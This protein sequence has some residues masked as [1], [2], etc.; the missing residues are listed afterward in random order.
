MKLWKAFRELLC[1]IFAVLKICLELESPRHSLK[2]VE[3]CCLALCTIVCMGSDLKTIYFMIHI[4]SYYIET[5]TIVS[6][7]LLIILKSY[8]TTSKLSLVNLAMLLFIPRLT[9]LLTLITK[10]LSFLSENDNLAI[11]MCFRK[12]MKHLQIPT[13]IKT[14]TLAIKAIQI[15][16]LCVDMYDF[17]PLT[18]PAVSACLLNK[19]HTTTCLPS[20][21]VVFTIICNC[22]LFLMATPT[23]ILCA[24]LCVLCLL[25]WKYVY[26]YTCGKWVHQIAEELYHDT[27][28]IEK[29]MAYFSIHQNF[30]DMLL[31]NAKIIKWPPRTIQHL[32]NYKTQLCDDVCFLIEQFDATILLECKLAPNHTKTKCTFIAWI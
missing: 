19:S 15:E 17:G 22:I 1:S 28:R 11:F 32:F 18:L 6:C 8:M 14:F 31:H 3:C 29:L 9:L 23:W 4:R 5:L 27:A 13:Q 24:S 2:N 20:W 21:Q 12:Q 26:L 25:L 7:T 30:D 16:Q 10:F